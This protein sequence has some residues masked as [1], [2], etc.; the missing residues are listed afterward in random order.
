MFELI[1]LIAALGASIGGHV[2]SR[3]FVRRR[4]SF[5][6]AVQK[7]A[8]AIAAGARDTRRRLPWSS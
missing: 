1:G 7:P 8:I 6:E 3:R 2:Q 5:V 4:L